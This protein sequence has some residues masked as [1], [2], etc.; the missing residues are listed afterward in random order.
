MKL[1]FTSDE[2]RELFEAVEWSVYAEAWVNDED[3]PW[4]ST[5]GDLQVERSVMECVDDS[6]PLRLCFT[7]TVPDGHELSLSAL[8]LFLDISG[9]VNGEQLIQWRSELRSEL[10]STRAFDV[11]HNT[12]IMNMDTEG[13]HYATAFYTETFPRRWKGIEVFIS[14]IAVHRALHE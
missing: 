1:K 9:D 14:P 11:V 13:L 10:Y 7:I 5:L 3:K 6:V 4:M 8:D 2:C 12:P